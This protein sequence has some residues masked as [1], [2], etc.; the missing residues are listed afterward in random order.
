MKGKRDKASYD[1]CTETQKQRW[2]SIV[3]KNK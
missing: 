1:K 2:L 3:N